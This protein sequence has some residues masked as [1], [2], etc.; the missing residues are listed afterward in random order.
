MSYSGERFSV[1]HLKNVGIAVSEC[2]ITEN[3]PGH[4]VKLRVYG[5][6]SAHFVISGKG[7][8]T[9]DGE[10]FSLSAGEGFMIMP[11]AVVGY[12]ADEDDP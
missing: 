1:P 8:V 9:S 10:R 12:T 3:S 11:N 6:Y 5:E 7:T 2:G 4:S